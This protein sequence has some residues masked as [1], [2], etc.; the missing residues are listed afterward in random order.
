MIPVTQ[1]RTGWGRGQCIQAAVASILE[2]GLTDVPDLWNGRE[3][4]RGEPVE[5]E[6]AFEEL[7]A[8]V[9]S[10]GFL[11][12]WGDVVR[13]IPLDIPGLGAHFADWP[14]G[15]Y[16]LL[17][18]PNHDGVSHMVVARAGAVA[19]DPN[20]SRRGI[21]A[22][23]GVGFLL[24]LSDLPEGVDAHWPMATMVFGE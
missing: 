23:D 1:E 24:P 12:A 11:Y 8:Y 21:T 19:W 2:V 17:G 15:G 6:G 18:G 14:W 22:V 20:P 10:R 13:P 7:V 9:R 16:H 5:R 4:V 3:P